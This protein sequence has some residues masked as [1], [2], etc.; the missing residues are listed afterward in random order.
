MYQIIYCFLEE[1]VDLSV[2]HENYGTS[3]DGG[4]VTSDDTDTMILRRRGKAGKK[5]TPKGLTHVADEVGEVFWKVAVSETKL[6][7]GAT[8]KQVLYGTPLRIF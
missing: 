8:E 1:F 3:G 7:I 2:I 6:T 4:G 5:T